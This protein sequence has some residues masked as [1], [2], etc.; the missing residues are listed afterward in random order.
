MSNDMLYLNEDGDQYAVLVSRGFGAGWSTWNPSRRFAY[1]KRVIELYL[2]GFKLARPNRDFLP[3][4]REQLERVFH[5]GLGYTISQL[6]FGGWND[7]ELVWVSFGVYWR[8]T[9]YDGSERI[10]FLDIE[11]DY[12]CFNK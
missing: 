10:E 4:E 2:S 1:D 7:L 11:N 5:D 3:E 9:E 12:T 8:I 6:Y